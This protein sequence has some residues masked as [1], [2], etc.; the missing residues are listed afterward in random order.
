MSLQGLSNSRL[1]GFSGILQAYGIAALRGSTPCRLFIYDGH[2]YVIDVET[3]S[4][5]VYQTDGTKT[6]EF[7]V[8]PRPD[9]TFPQ[10][11]CNLK[12]VSFVHAN[13]D[14]I[15]VSFDSYNVGYDFSGNEISENYN[16]YRTGIF[17]NGYF[18]N[19]YDK[20]NIGVYDENGNIQDLFSLDGNFFN[21]GIDVKNDKVYCIVRRL[22]SFGNSSVLMKIF[23]LSG[24][25]LNEFEYFEKPGVPGDFERIGIESLLFTVNGDYCNSATSKDGGKVI[26][27]N[28]IIT[29]A[30]LNTFQ[31]NYPVGA[32]F[33]DDNY[34]YYTSR[35]TSLILVCEKDTGVIVNEW[36]TND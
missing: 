13:A 35:D 21:A 27:Q 22:P 1:Q 15:L 36:S 31:L 9:Q 34:V 26:Y 19:N 7:P 4:I 30:E 18:Y 33:A 24:D 11:T 2:I 3:Q 20:S 14:R 32:A 16:F 8:E 23:N 29:G 5:K 6:F 25:L 17:Y 28:S 12:I 10:I